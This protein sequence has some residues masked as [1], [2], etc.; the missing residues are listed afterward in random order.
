MR[1]IILG[2]LV[3]FWVMVLGA[4]GV[5]SAHTVSSLVLG[6]II[7]ALALEA[8]SV[9]LRPNSLVSRAIQNRMLKAAHPEHAGTDHGANAGSS[10]S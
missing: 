3:L 4:L 1:E 2:G 5:I 6:T 7:A 10:P 8:V 9:L